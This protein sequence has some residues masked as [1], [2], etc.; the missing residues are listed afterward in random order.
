M[1]AAEVVTR[2]QQRSGDWWYELRISLWAEPQLP[3]GKT[4]PEPF[5]VT[6]RGGQLEYGTFLP[7]SS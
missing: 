6:F 7:Y 3:G 1:A 2:I 5:A 4:A